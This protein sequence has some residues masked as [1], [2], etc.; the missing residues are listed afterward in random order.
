MDNTTGILKPF[1]SR[2]NE[3]Y[4]HYLPIE[5]KQN[6][7]EMVRSG[8]RGITAKAFSSS[9]DAAV[10]PRVIFYAPHLELEPCYQMWGLIH[11][12]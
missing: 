11:I 8:T 1:G 9:G 4:Y 6:Q 5:L 7:K 12:R 10:I 2:C 3:V